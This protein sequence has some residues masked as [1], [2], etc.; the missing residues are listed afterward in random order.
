MK[1][2]LVVYGGW[3]GH[4]PTQVA[5]LY[6]KLLQAEDFDVEL[7]N[8][9]D[10]FLDEEKLKSM[11]IIIPHWTMGTITTAQL[12]PVLKA[13]ASGVGMAGCHAGMC[14]A[15]HDSVDW[16]FMTG[17]QWVAHPGGQQVRY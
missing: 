8:T 17:G 12:E 1:K 3:E 15:F 16:Q 11:D 4:E 7:S 5:K 9:L 2:A 13:V 6:E 14:D 10:A